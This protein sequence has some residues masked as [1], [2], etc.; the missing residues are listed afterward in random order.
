[1]IDCGLDWRDRV[2]ALLPTA[3]VLTHAHPDHAAGLADGSPCPVYATSDT[4]GL[5]GRFPIRDRRTMPMGRFITIEN[6]RFKS[7]PVE[8]SRRAPAVGL[9]VCAGKRCLVYVPDVAEIPDRPRPLLGIELYIGDGATLRRPMARRNRGILVG[10]APMTAQ[11]AWCE[12]AGVRQVIFTHCGSAI[13][14]ESAPAAD[15]TVRQLGMQR[16]LDAR[17]A[18]DRLQ[19]SLGAPLFRQQ[20]RSHAPRPPTR[21]TRVMSR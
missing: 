6:L 4:W 9:R 20:R 11:L 16:G 8:H 21:P 15:A 7:F 1:M 13:V 10:H 17:I 18:E 19:L 5:I 2:H 3:I 14:R 12:E